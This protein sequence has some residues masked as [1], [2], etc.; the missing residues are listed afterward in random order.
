MSEKMLQLKL[1]GLPLMLKLTVSPLP[2]SHDL[3]ELKRQL[4]YLAD[5]QRNRLCWCGAACH[6]VRKRKL[7]GEG[8]GEEDLEAV[9]EAAAAAGRGGALRFRQVFC[10]GVA[11]GV[12]E[13]ERKGLAGGAG[14]T[15]SRASSCLETCATRPP[16]ALGALRAGLPA[17]FASCIVSVGLKYRNTGRL[18]SHHSVRTTDETMV[19]QCNWAIL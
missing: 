14:D 13:A 12:C 18:L 17:S 6:N 3:A 10:R 2:K 11:A 1:I 15:W 4:L 9:P 8:E 7:A 5:Q 19:D 16:D